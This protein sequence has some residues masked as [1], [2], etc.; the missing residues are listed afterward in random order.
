M[1]F[2]HLLIRIRNPLVEL[3]RQNQHCFQFSLNQ[4]TSL[5]SK[6]RTDPQL[7]K[8]IEQ[9]TAKW[10]FMEDAYFMTSLSIFV[11][12][13]WMRFWMLRQCDSSCSPGGGSV[14]WFGGY[15]AAHL[16]QEAW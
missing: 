13:A 9:L 11:S 4:E 12:F 1:V 15:A 2:P 3:K 6:I 16:G 10:A 8:C 7:C 5:E 14:T